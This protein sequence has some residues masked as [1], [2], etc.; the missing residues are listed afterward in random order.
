VCAGASDHHFELVEGVMRCFFS[1]LVI[2]LGFCLVLRQRYSQG[3]IVLLF[4]SL[5]IM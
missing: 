1:F 3:Q 5:A 2:V 4:T